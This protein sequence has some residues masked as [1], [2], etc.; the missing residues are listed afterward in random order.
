M[1]LPGPQRYAWYRGRLYTQYGDTQIIRENFDTMKAWLDGMDSF[2]FEAN[3]KT[4][5]GLLEKLLV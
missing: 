5:T 3:G 4:Y 1:A 2:D